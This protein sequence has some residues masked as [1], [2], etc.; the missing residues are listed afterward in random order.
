[1]NG[2]QALIFA[3]SRHA[4][5]PEGTDFARSKRQEMIIQALLEKLRQQ[6]ALTD[7][8][9]ADTYF[10][11]VQNNFS[12][13]FSVPEITKVLQVASTLDFSTD[14]VMANWSNDIGFLCDST[15]GDGAYVLRYG[16]PDDC[17]AIAGVNSDSPYRAQ[18]VQYV[19][20]LLQAATGTT[21][22]TSAPSTAPGT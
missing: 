11:I 20:N 14:I 22:T 1:M 5:G 17:T 10:K 6:G 8:S 16:T 19:Q 15:D 21:T 3:R 7:V 9:K 2:T 12:S 4:A 13:S 18:A